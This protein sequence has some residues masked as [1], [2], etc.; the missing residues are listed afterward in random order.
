MTM[1]TRGI[2][3]LYFFMYFQFLT[4]PSAIHSMAVASLLARV[5]SVRA[6]VSGGANIYCLNDN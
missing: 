2:S 5:A 3:S 1:R 6:S 4:L